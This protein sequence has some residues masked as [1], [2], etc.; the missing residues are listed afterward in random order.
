MSIQAAFF[1]RLTRDPEQRQING[2]Y[3]QSTMASFTVAVDAGHKDK[4]GNYPT[5][6]IR[7]STLNRSDFVLKY[8]H[9]A[10]PIF[11]SGEL[12]MNEY[13][14]KNGQNRQSLECRADHVE[15][16]PR[17]NTQQSQQQWQQPQQGYQ[18]SNQ[19]PFNN[20]PQGAPQNGPQNG[21]YQQQGNQPQ[22]RPNTPQQQNMGQMNNFN[23]AMPTNGQQPNN[24][25]QS[26]NGQQAFGPA[27]N[28]YRQ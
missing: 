23:A 22:Q 24:N 19:M 4:S 15:F 13:Q 25:Q 16:V 8:F 1:G 27:S 28:G 10:S 9:K 14:D 6:F 18:P 26:N 5:T 12:F 7:V 20:A 2:N 11:V 17:D 21:F 3:G